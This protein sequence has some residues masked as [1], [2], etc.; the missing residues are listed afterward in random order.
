MSAKTRIIAILIAIDELGNA[1]L[2]PVKGIPAAGNAHFTISQ[3]L[4][5]MRQQHRR[6]GCI[7]CAILTFIFRWFNQNIKNYDHCHEAMKD[8]PESLPTEG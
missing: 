5:E 6:V 1:I 4:A 2:G 7:G 3:R 8:F